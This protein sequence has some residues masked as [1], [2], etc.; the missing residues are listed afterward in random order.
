MRTKRNDGTVKIRGHRFKYGHCQ[1]CGLRHLWNSEIGP[2]LCTGSWRSRA[3]S[4]WSRWRGLLGV[5]FQAQGKER[6]P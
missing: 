3:W 2:G 5:V 1:R 6:K 4:A